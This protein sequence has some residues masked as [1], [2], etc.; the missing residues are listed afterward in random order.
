[1]RRKNTFRLLTLLFLLSTVSLYSQKI[2][3]APKGTFTIAVMA[4]TQ[5]YSGKGTKNSP[6]SEDEVTNKVFDSQTKWL[7]NNYKKQ[8]II[9]VSHAG[10]VVDINNIDQWDVAV[11]HLN[12]LH[13]KIPYGISLGNHDMESNGNS[14][15]Y[16]SYFPAN[17]FA[18][19]D[20]Y[21]GSF[22]NNTNSYQLLSSNNVNILMLHIECNATD[23]VLAWADEVLS[24]NKDRFAI[25]T[26]HMFLGPRERPVEPEDY[27]DKPKGI[28]V[29]NKTF[30]EQGNSPED[31]W[32][33]C[34]KKHKNIKMILCGDQSRTN[35]LHWEVAGDNGNVV[36]ALLSDYSTNNGG[37]LRLY[38]FFPKENIIKVKTYNTTTQEFID[39]TKIVSDTKEH[40][41]VINMPLKQ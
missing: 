39:T 3:R 34:F 2:D 16:Q 31:L 29:W 40:S 18:G 21:G 4:D 11:N 17:R 8:N 9:F 10:D 41:F 33:K 37:G 6:D 23:S 12:R 35:A 1:M 24:N 25:I 5:S 22:K 13:G 26:T 20:W 32:N 38:R 27:Y 28:M 7:V 19:F 14:D 15:L 36:H 30:G